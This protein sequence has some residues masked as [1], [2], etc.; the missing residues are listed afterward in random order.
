MTPTQQL[1]A[2]GSQPAST[3][4][5]TPGIDQNILD[6]V[7]RATNLDQVIGK[8]PAHQKPSA[9]SA[10]LTR[11]VPLIE[12]MLPPKMRGQAGWL[13]QRAAFYF[14]NDPRLV[15]C[16]PTQF[17][18]AVMQAAGMGLPLDGQ[19]CYCIKYKTVYEAVPDYKGLI[20][21]AKSAG[22]INDAQPFLVKEN[23]VWEWEV[24][25]E[26]VHKID[27]TKPRGKTQAAYCRIVLP[28]GEVRIEYLDAD[29]LQR[30]RDA[31]P[32]KKDGKVV[33]PRAAWADE[34]DKKGPVKRGL[35][36]FRADPTM[37]RALDAE[38]V[39]EQLDALVALDAAGDPPPL[40]YSDEAPPLP[41]RDVVKRD[42]TALINDAKGAGLLDAAGYA[43]LE[44]EVGIADKNSV[45]TAQ[46]VALGQRIQALF[47][48]G[49]DGNVFTGGDVFGRN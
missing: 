18:R 44:S 35:K 10:A 19:L 29:E 45:T 20:A 48:A 41:A 1:P 37:Q 33:G 7:L 22:L 40:T 32:A 27:R 5:A 28:T 14:E 17:L 47:Q 49:Q 16:P 3:I 11:Y 34:M 25:K 15:A 42:V 13:A 8:M 39:A 6:A 30:L 9:I 2:H 12:K 31:S 38:E 26:P 36:F 43:K 46:L 21:V 24:G 23:D 4:Q